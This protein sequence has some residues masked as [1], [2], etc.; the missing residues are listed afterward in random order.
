[1]GHEV[2]IADDGP[3]ALET[4]RRFK[5]EVALLDIGLPAMDGYEL[6]QRLRALDETPSD[7]RLVAVTGYGLERDRRRALEA[8]FDAHLVKPVDI[9]NL[10]NICCQ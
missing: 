5:P 2:A 6:A 8:G 10:L 1:M 9:S 4:A 7:L 3:T